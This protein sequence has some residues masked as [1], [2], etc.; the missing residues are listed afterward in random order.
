MRAVLVLEPNVDIARRGEQTFKGRPKRE[1]DK[2]QDTAASGF[3]DDQP[4]AAPISESTPARLRPVTPGKSTAEALRDFERSGAGQLMQDL[5]PFLGTFRAS[6]SLRESWEGL[7]VV[8]RI[9]GSAGLIASTAAD[10]TIV[11]GLVVRSLG[12]GS[13]VITATAT[14]AD[15]AIALR[16]V[17]KAQGKGETDITVEAAT[18]RG[19][20]GEVGK[21]ADSA[22]GDEITIAM[23][24]AAGELKAAAK[25]DDILRA[26]RNPTKAVVEINE[27]LGADEIARFAEA[28]GDTDVNK[29]VLRQTVKKRPPVTAEE[30]K[31]YRVLARKWRM[32]VREI[33]GL[34][35]VEDT[36]KP[37]KASTKALAR[38]LQDEGIDVTT[39]TVTLRRG[40]RIRDREV[41]EVRLQPKPPSLARGDGDVLVKVDPKVASGVKV[42]SRKVSRRL[43]FPAAIASTPPLAP[44]AAGEPAPA[45]PAIEP[46]DKVKPTKATTTTGR[47]ASPSPLTEPT[48]SKAPAPSEITDPPPPTKA[49]S[50]TTTKTA[51]AKKPAPRSRA[52]FSLPDGTKLARGR[53]P[54]VVIWEQGAVDITFDL[55]TGVRASKRR[56]QPSTKSPQETLEVIRTDTTPPKPQTLDMGKVKVFITPSSLRFRQRVT[57]ERVK[58]QRIRT[59]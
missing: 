33:E 5:T 54:R 49:P 45:K 37:I 23:Q 4:P 35:R 42:T 27:P 26:K 36:A 38:A 55:D 56:A 44:T 32:P 14:K 20:L 8:E 18:N 25:V 11:G 41:R 28:A 12:K 3:F 57:G 51:G 22:R 21:L 30:L 16:R 31:E 10:A 59:L 6:K 15:D 1:P 48:S 58:R 13:L 24:P 53:Y 39:E 50:R 52:R 46:A 47:S 40:A 7:S 2:D 19:Y 9:G 17:V 34:L 43:A 29:L